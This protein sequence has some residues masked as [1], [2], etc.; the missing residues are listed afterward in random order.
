MPPGGPPD[1]E[2]PQV[3][4]ITP[5]TN[6][7]NVQGNSIAFQFNEVVS[8]R[9]QSAPTLAEMFQVSPSTGPVSI[10]WRRTQVEVT[11]KGG[12]RP[13]TTYTVRLLPGMVDLAQNVDSTGMTVVFSTGP[14]L[15]SGVIAGRVFDWVAG[16]PAQRASVEAMSLPD[17]AIWSTTADSTGLFSI[18]HMPA[19]T[20]LLQALVD[21]NRNRIVDA[22]ELFDS[23]TVTLADS[24]HREMLAAIRDSLGPGLSTVEPKD[25]LTWRVA[26]DRPLDTLFVATVANFTLKSQDSTGVP[27]A[28]VLTQADLDR[29]A[30]DT[31]RMRAVQDSVRQAAIADSVRAADSAQ[32]VAAPPARPTGR[33][34]GAQ[35]RAPT[36]APADTAV[37]PPPT[38]QAK[39]PINTLFLRFTQPLVADTNYRLRAV[40][41]VSVTGAT[42][43]SERVFRT[44][45]PVA[46]PDSGATPDTGSRSRD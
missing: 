38:P 24:F 45:K 44:P 46:R 27:I 1:R 32:V 20:Y 29:L 42:R 36:A 6:A 7:I 19:G 14:T 26:F 43:T 23:I 12:L 28:Q 34:P 37:A 9:P 21:Q 40:D 13:N 3:V 16:R 18:G 2:P 15:S 33:R 8:E 10:S 30:A 41:F 11:P 39:S 22:R 4:R 17:S 35:T 31:T 25:S 5:D